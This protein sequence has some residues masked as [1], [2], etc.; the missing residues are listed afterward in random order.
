MY[1]VCVYVY[2]RIFLLLN[3]SVAERG[4][5]LV[6]NF[7]S[8]HIMHLKVTFEIPCL[9]KNFN[10]FLTLLRYYWEFKGVCI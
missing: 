10:F 3:F 9:T 8:F 5:W 2:I 4:V 6:V 1:I 7:I